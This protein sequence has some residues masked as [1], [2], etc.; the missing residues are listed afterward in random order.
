MFFK[1]ILILK[2]ILSDYKGWPLQSK[3]G[4]FLIKLYN[5]IL[6]L[7]TAIVF[8]NELR[9]YN[10]IAYLF[11]NLVCVIEYLF[12]ALASTIKNVKIDKIFSKMDVIEDLLYLKNNKIVEIQKDLFVIIVIVIQS[13]LYGCYL[14]VERMKLD[15]IVFGI[16]LHCSVDLEYIWRILIYHR[17]HIY[18]KKLK[19]NI[20]EKIGLNELSDYKQISIC[21]ETYVHIIDILNLVGSQ[22]NVLVSFNTS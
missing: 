4:V 14:F 11:W 12:V 16:V 19:L 3:I 2:L 1:S 20:H 10:T 18:L 21:R 22:T 6:V 5:F 13:F 17:I 7:A 9:S 8:L 15:K